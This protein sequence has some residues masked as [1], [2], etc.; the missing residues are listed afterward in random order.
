MPRARKD[1]ELLQAVGA[2]VAAARR[3]RGFTQ[4]SL[5]EA[6]GVEPVTLSRWETGDRALSLTTLAR[7]AGALGVGIGDLLD[8]TRALPKI[9]VAPEYLELARTYDAMTEPRKAL[10]LKL[11]RELAR[12]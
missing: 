3:D 9:E 7:V 5:A 11:A 6:V 8:T 4:E 12:G 10:L 2:R 1:R